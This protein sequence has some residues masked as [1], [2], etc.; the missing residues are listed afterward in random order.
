M[1][2][3]ALRN[4]RRPRANMRNANPPSRAIHRIINGLALK[5]SHD[6]PSIVVRP[7]NSIVVVSDS[8]PTTYDVQALYADFVAQILNV[9]RA[10][11][12]AD[13]EYDFQIEDVRLWG[14][15]DGSA[16][17]RGRFVDLLTRAGDTQQILSSQ[18]DRPATNQRAVVGYRWPESQQRQVLTGVP[19]SSVQIFEHQAAT[20]A[21]IHL[22]WRV[23]P[24][25]P[26][27]ATAPAC[28]EAGAPALGAGNGV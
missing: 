23:T 15:V 16:L 19:T 14:P 27:L 18:E 1:N 25:L 26:S 22:R 3:Q 4:N 11:V 5:P 21:Y 28:A 24:V 7:W 6:P 12:P 2:R 9:D 13:L 20:L 8:P 10:S 17:V